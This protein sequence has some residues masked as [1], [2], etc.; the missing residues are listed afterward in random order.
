MLVRRSGECPCTRPCHEPVRRSATAHTWLLQLTLPDSD[1]LREIAP[2][3]R[4]QSLPR[5]LLVSQAPIAATVGSHRSGTGKTACLPLRLR[6]Y[7]KRNWSRAWDLTFSAATA[8][9]NSSKVMFLLWSTTSSALQNESTFVPQVPE[10]NHPEVRHL[11]SVFTDVLST[12]HWIFIP[13]RGRG[14]CFHFWWGFFRFFFFSYISHIFSFSTINQGWLK[15]VLVYF[16]PVEEVK[17]PF[18]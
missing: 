12:F 4:S 15:K 11:L 6:E 17:K 9:K 7:Q 16:F 14:G 3:P 5:G 2:Q 1:A 10:H 8:A 13:K 18:C